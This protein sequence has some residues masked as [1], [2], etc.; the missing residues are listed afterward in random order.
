MP[1]VNTP[2]GAIAYDDLGSGPPVVLL[3]ATLHDRTDYA[4]VAG[5]LARRHRVLAI[6]WPGHGDSPA[7]A[8]GVTAVFLA[9]VLEQ[10]VAALDVTGAVVVGN[11]VGGFAACRLA[12]TQPSRVAGL[13]LVNGSGFTRWSPI[14]RAFC[15]AMGHPWSVR[16]TFRFSVP[17][18]MR[19]RTALDEQVVARVVARAQTPEGARVAASLWR[20]F[21]DPAA[22]LRALADRIAVPTLIT[23]GVKDRTLRKSWGRSMHRAIAGSTYIEFDTGHLPFTSD[24]QGW[25]AAVTPFLA[26][27][28]DPRAVIPACPPNPPP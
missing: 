1:V 26:G 9:D 24:Q 8:S 13:I 4:A 11:S 5:E 28:S 14:S 10:F 20:S 15:A 12:I 17:A 22:D 21:P 27:L 3:H 19:A 2:S 25:L 23:W 6:D 16:S 18:Y 7:P